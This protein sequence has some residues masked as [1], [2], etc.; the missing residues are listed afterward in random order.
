MALCPQCLAKLCYATGA[1]PQRRFGKLI[2]FCK[3]NGLKTEQEF[4]QK[5]LGALRSD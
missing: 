3:A 1:E 4:Y 2:S 5:L